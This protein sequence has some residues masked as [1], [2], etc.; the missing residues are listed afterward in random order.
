[1]RFTISDWSGWSQPNAITPKIPRLTLSET[2]DVSAIPPLLRRKLNNMG[3]A[4]ASQALK[5]LPKDSS[6][7]VVYCSQHGDIDRTVKVLRDLADAEPVSPTHFSLA[8][9][10]AICGIISIQTGNR[11]TVS[12][13]SAGQH[14]IVPVLLEALGLLESGEPNVL[15]VICDAYLPDIY[16][17][18]DSQPEF[19][20][21]IAFM[22]NNEGSDE[23]EL[24]QLVDAAKTEREETWSHSPLNFIEFLGSKKDKFLFKHNGCIWQLLRIGVG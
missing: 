2:P 9:H 18:I 5:L 20:Y 15:C 13:L 22:L 8:V 7:P 10:N 6:T 23:F 12:A 3:R 14:G 4:C 19:P 21:A 16:K 1:M 17:D 24:Q 11:G